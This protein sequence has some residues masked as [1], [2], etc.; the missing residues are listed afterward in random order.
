MKRVEQTKELAVFNIFIC[1]S[2]IFDVLRFSTH[3]DT[4]LADACWQSMKDLGWA[5]HLHHR[6][7]IALL[8]TW[9]KLQYQTFQTVDDLC[10]TEHSESTR[11]FDV[12]GHWF[13]SASPHIVTLTL[14]HFLIQSINCIPYGLVKR[15]MI[16][17]PIIPN[18]LSYKLFFDR[19]RSLW[20]FNG[21]CCWNRLIKPSEESTC[22]YEESNV[23]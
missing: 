8:D 4:T 15:S 12:A 14:L 23:E 5:W 9:W 2:N 21:H 11:R 1:A 22:S 18:E 19:F 6:R 7:H 16:F 20:Q 3:F 13:D 10:M 17:C